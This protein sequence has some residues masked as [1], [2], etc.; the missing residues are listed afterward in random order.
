MGYALELC[1][2]SDENHYQEFIC[3]ICTQLVESPVLTECQH[4]F[5]SG[6]CDQWIGAGARNQEQNH[7]CP[8]CSAKLQ[9]S[10]QPLSSASPLAW[11]VLGRIRV[12]CPLAR[13][14]WRGEYSEVSSH[15]LNSESHVG[16]DRAGTME[17]VGEGLR[18]QADHKADA[19]L[20]KEAI[21]LYSKALASHTDARTLAAR[22][23][24]WAACSEHTQALADARQALKLDGSHLPAH[25]LFVRACIQIGRFDDAARHLD[26]IVLKDDDLA[27]LERLAEALLEAERTG[28]DALESGDFKRAKEVFDSM[29]GHT[30]ASSV[31][32]WLAR[33]ELSLGQ[34]D[35]AIRRTRELIKENPSDASALTVRGQAFYLNCDFDQAWKHLSEALRLDP[36][37]AMTQGA[38]KKARKVQR[39]AEGAKSAAFNRS[40]SEAVALSSEAISVA[41]PPMRAPL[42]AMLF[43]ERAA[44]YLRLKEYDKCLADCAKALY[45]SDDDC[46]PA[47]LTRASALH[48]LG[49][50]EE[51]LEGVKAMRKLYEHD[52][53]INHAYQRANFE[54]R[55]MRRPKL[56]ELLQVPSIAS[57][58]E[59]KAAYKQR[60]LELHP[61]KAPVGDEA[62]R[63]AAEERFKQLG[64]ALEILTD[65]FK[66][67]LWDEGYDREA[68]EERVQAAQRAARQHTSDGCCGGGGGGGGGCHH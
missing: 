10:P 61:D 60:A 16:A 28:R 24:A 33:A 22:G 44:A 18:E 67:K 34:C 15:L 8:T 19:K 55:K 30:A 68:I 62:A 39:A 51:A 27:E 46:K 53:Q 13:C 1:Q 57:A 23:R 50:H 47:A 5:C 43:A 9:A 14:S 2:D 36:D 29:L 45:G 31:Q 64:E 17:S 20:Y 63:K 38:A 21:T 37:D 3:V 42:H 6:C 52:T 48:A 35:Q 49:R 25:A 40:F 66:R 11:R 12:R 41:D 65:D 4:V 26:T 32:L 56:Y 7:K 58:P 54:V 59:I